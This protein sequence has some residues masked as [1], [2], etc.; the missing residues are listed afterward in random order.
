MRTQQGGIRS[1]D[2]VQDYHHDEYLFRKWLEFKKSKKKLFVLDGGLGDNYM[3]LQAISIP[4]GAV[5]ATCY[6]HIF[7]DMDVEII[8]IADAQQIVN[9]MDYNV[10]AWAARNKWTGHLVD[11]FEQMYKELEEA[12]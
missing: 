4:K 12:P 10:Y 8:S 9:V 2:N 11:A 6:P 5:V 1:D 7:K 3:C